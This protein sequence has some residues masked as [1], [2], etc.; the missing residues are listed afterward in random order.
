[1][2]LERRINLPGKNEF[3]A[4]AEDVKREV[5]LD[6]AIAEDIYAGLS[7]SEQARTSVAALAER[8][9]HRIDPRLV[10]VLYRP[11]QGK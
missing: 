10:D 11:M 1:M 7:P 9:R 6:E 2:S 3:A 5:G 4:T 8:V